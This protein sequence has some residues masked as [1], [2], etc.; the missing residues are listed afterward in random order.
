MH[1]INFYGLCQ[2]MIPDYMLLH[3]DFKSKRTFLRL[4]IREN[5]KIS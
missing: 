5:K 2:I 4:Q 3:P 1:F